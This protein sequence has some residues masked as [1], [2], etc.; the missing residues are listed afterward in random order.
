M[1]LALCLAFARAGQGED[2]ERLA[3]TA[4]SRVADG[5][6][7]GGHR[8]HE[9]AVSWDP[10]RT[11]IIICDMWDAHWCQGATRRVVEI[12][13]RMNDFA[14]A[15]RRRGVLV[16]HAPSSCMEAYQDHPARKRAQSA[17]AAANQPADIAQWCRSIPEEEAGRYPVDQSDGGCDCQPTCKGGDPW[18][19][20]IA[21]IEID[22]ADAISDSGQEI[23]NLFEERRIENVILMGVHT[24]MCV[25]GRPF[26]L[27][28]MARYGKNV[29]LVRDLTDTMYNSRA[30][31]YVSHFTGTDLIVEHIEKYVCPTITSDQLLGGERQRFSEDGRRR[32]VIVSAE[33]EYRTEQSL[34]EFA[35]R[36]LG[37]DFQVEFVLGDPQE[38]HVLPGIEA[39]DRADVALF[40]IRRRVLPEDQMQTIRRYLESGKPLVGIRT[41]SHPFALRAGEAMPPDRVAWEE[42]DR[43][44]LGCNYQGH[45]GNTSDDQG[46]SFVWVL[47]QAVDNPLV[48]GVPTAEFQVRSWLYKSLPLADTATELLRGRV[49]DRKP[50]EPVAWTNTTEWNGRV[51]YTSLG[52]IDEFAMPAFRRL[53]LNGIYWAAALPAPADVSVEGDDVGQ[54]ALPH[55][56]EVLP[57][58]ARL[59]MEGDIASTLVDGVDRFL[60]RK[61]DESVERRARHW[62]RDLASDEA[63]NAS[64]E[65]NRRRLAHILGVRDPRIPFD[66]PELVGTTAQPALV[67]KGDGFDV[68]A[69]RW[70]AFGDVHGEGLLL[71][72]TGR[73]PVA[74]LVAIPDA[75]QLPE[76]I[77]GLVEG[78]PPESQ[79]ARRLAEAGCRV[80]VPVLIDRHIEVRNG[81]S[82]LSSREFIYRS[83]FELGRHLAGYEVQKVLAAVDWFARE[84]GEADP[85]IGVIGYGEGGMLALYAGAL[86]TRIDTTCI[87]G[88]FGNRHD[89]WQHPIDRNVFG[90]LDQFGDAELASMVYPRDL[91]VD[92]S[93][94]PELDLPGNGGAPSQLRSPTVAGVQAEW[95]RALA[96]LQGSDGVSALWVGGEVWA[97]GDD[98][99]PRPFLVAGGLAMF[100]VGQHLLDGTSFDPAGDLTPEHFRPDF[101]PAPRQARQLH[102]LDRHSQWLLTESAYVRAEYMKNLDT[103]SLDAYQKS[104]EPYRQTFY[105]DVIGRLDDPMLAPRPRSRKA[106]DQEKWTGY[107]VVMDVYPDVIAYGILLVPKDLKEG[108]RRPCV[109]CQHGLE[110]R[111]QDVVEGDKPAYH[112]FAARLAERGFVTFAPQ[113]LYIFTDRFRTL[114]RKANPLGKT[115]FSVITPQHQQIVDWLQTLPYVDPDRVGFYGLSYG[116]KTAMRVPALVTDYCLS[117]CSA[118]FGE[119][120]WKN[121]S[122]RS[123]YS[124]VWT[125]E[126]EI[127]EFDLGSTF[128]YAEMAAL[129]APRPFMVERGHFDGVEPDEAVAYEFAKVQ[130]LYQARLG[131][132]DRT[133]IE[134]FVGPHTINGVGTYDFLHRHLDWPRPQ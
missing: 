85:K 131:I 43:D 12:A 59:E 119:W 112:D 68:Y 55:G 84:A 92:A 25:L 45:H 51:F 62:R 29:V 35:R 70:P 115:L 83:A 103:S 107:E 50:H 46:R 64:I 118:D 24:N 2:G 18:R 81:R 67:G 36:F 63:Y 15:A 77:A 90:L 129:I 44:I 39:L 95:D 88:Y 71:A 19:R 7:A 108:E 104:A 121:S 13:P 74:D 10:A 23:W 4:R 66:G 28:N 128:N 120:V 73:K 123:P 109:V 20:Q 132:G 41:A 16:V 54:A 80:V 52:H 116:G 106:Y 47:P 113:N 49:E 130:H 1:G 98:G 99:G 22:D 30:W 75:D 11:A 79:F 133:E 58:T 33:D 6:V 26:G 96:L 27:R 76:Q 117:I 105:D 69:I 60:L 82:Q 122:T 91:I 32:L 111:P 86:D 89:I 101:D 93:T 87:S 134:W 34:P 53:L 65:P 8:V 5:A 125:G 57:G 127:F 42:F 38:R 124:Y 21:A 31:P 110:G 48:A 56:A 72:P 97:A 126:Y 78:V 102:E 3:L 114:Q 37:R 17:P 40:S 9:A 94:G 100:A 14:S 61:I